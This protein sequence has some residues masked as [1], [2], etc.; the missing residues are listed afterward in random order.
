MVW[1][2]VGNKPENN[3]NGNFVK[4]D[5]EG[6]VLEGEWLGVKDGKYGDLGIIVTEAGEICFPIHTVLQR[7]MVE[8]VEG[9]N[10]RIEYLGKVKGKRGQWYKHFRVEVDKS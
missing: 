5:T 3:N 8:I 6:Q 4:W 10:C 7:K 1:Q 2:E 9:E